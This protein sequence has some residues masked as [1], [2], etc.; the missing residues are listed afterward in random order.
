[1]PFPF[2]NYSN[3]RVFEVY[4]LG[5]RCFQSKLNWNI[6]FQVLESE[7]RGEW[8]IRSIC[9][10]EFSHFID[11]FHWCY[12]NYAC[13]LLLF[14]FF[15]FVFLILIFY[16]HVKKTNSILGLIRSLQYFT[17]YHSA[18]EAFKGVFKRLVET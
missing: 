4:Y 7:L 18:L 9:L 14:L 8:V 15:V 3:F 13:L 2:N 16:F 17:V 12:P 5:L 6:G 11:I 10:K 1:M